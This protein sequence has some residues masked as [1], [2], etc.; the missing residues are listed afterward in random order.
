MDVHVYLRQYKF[1]MFL[2]RLRCTY[3]LHNIRLCD[4]L[5]E[6]LNGGILYY[7]IAAIPHVLDNFGILSGLN[8][9]VVVVQTSCPVQ[10]CRT[11]QCTIPQE[12][13]G[14][15]SLRF[16]LP[17][18]MCLRRAPSLRRTREPTP[19]KH[20]GLFRQPLEYSTIVMATR[21]VAALAA[22]NDVFT[23]SKRLYACG[24]QSL[25]TSC[26]SLQKHQRTGYHLLGSGTVP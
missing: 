25:V 23:R 16:L 10:Q 1:Y 13:G 24:R 18:I 15:S 11:F 6:I 9:N 12:I 19:W 8:D 7:Q 4:L 2:R 5:T 14:R 3:I 26:L 17:P 22:S 21:S 20:P